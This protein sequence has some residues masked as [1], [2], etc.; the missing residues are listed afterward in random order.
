M[1][2]M[3]KKILYSFKMEPISL[4]IMHNAKLK[5][6]KLIYFLNINYLGQQVGD[7]C[8]RLCLTSF[9]TFVYLIKAVVFI[10]KSIF[11]LFCLIDLLCD[12]WRKQVYFFLGGGGSK[13]KFIIFELNASIIIYFLIWLLEVFLGPRSPT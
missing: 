3:S 10:I 7:P 11:I 2:K 8:I 1:F 4:Q 13:L 6:I 12:Q 9:L 5:T